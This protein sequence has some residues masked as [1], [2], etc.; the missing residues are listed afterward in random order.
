M[1]VA[2]KK[3]VKE[4]TQNTEKYLP[5]LKDKNGAFSV[6][7]AKYFPTLKKLAEK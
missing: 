2:M 5:R 3:K 7:A 6:S 4:L 1:T